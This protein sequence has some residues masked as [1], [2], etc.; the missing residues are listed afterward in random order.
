M[1]LLRRGVY[2]EHGRRAPR[3]DKKWRFR[4]IA[5][6]SK[7]RAAISTVTM[8][9]FQQARKQES[10]LVHRFGFRI[11]CGMTTPIAGLREYDL[12]KQSQFAVLQI[13]VKS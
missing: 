9:L 12:K 6:D 7:N 4:V 10:R 5:S 2:P 3:N 13:D 8:G 11:K 1:R